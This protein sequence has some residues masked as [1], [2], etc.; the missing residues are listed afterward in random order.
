MTSI[1][2]GSRAR[3]TVATGWAIVVLGVALSSVAVADDTPTTDQNNDT[4]SQTVPVN[5]PTT[6]TTV[7]EPTTPVPAPE[8]DQVNP[9]PTAVYVAPEIDRAPVRRWY[10]PVGIA[11]SAGGGTSGFINDNLRGDTRIGGEWNVRLTFGTR[12]PLAF[13][14]SYIGSDQSI[15]ALGVNSNAMLLGNG[16]QGA[17][18]VN[19][20]IDFP[21]QPFFYGGVAWRRYQITNTALNAS[22][23]VNRDDVAE[24]PLG[25]G[26]AARYGGLIID[27]RGEYRLTTGEDLLPL[28]PTQNAS[29]NRWAANGSI[30]YEF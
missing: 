13:E 20:T 8:P 4:P 10:R 25:A 15:N 7:P 23:L 26:L 3:R 30:G 27:V 16:V 18:R 5:D 11:L 22:D 9:Q 19:T 14:A 21:L 2:I 12:S 17:L 1:L 24:F 28:S 29:M 6:D